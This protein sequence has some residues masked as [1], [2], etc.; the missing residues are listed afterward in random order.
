MNTTAEYPSLGRR[1]EHGCIQGLKGVIFTLLFVSA[2]GVLV[3][4]GTI[5]ADVA[6]RLPSE[7]AD[8]MRGSQIGSFLADLILRLPWINV[9]IV[10]AYDIVRIAGAISLAA[11]LPYTT[12]VKGHVAIEYFFH[13]LNRT[14][15]IVVDSAMR[16]LS[17]GLFG[18]LGWRSV[19]YGQELYDTHQVT[20]TL[21]WPIFWL[22]M[23]IGFCCF[24]V[25][26]VITYHL[27]YPRREMIKP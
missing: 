25:M 17:M 4:I 8:K 10:G 9:R 18:F 12:A 13:K 1:I 23:V 3:M 14:S 15:R 7:F 27:V 26:L 5:C 11:A 2:A 22:P 19:L 24:V 16:L 6:L 21:Q 20:Q